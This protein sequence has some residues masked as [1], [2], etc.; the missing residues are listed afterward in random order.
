MA[1]KVMDIMPPYPEKQRTYHRESKKHK[2]KRKASGLFWSIIL[3]I[4]LASF[5]WLFIQTA[6]FET[7]NPANPG[8]SSP[9][10]SFELFSG[11]G[12]S[13]LTDKD[14]PIV[15]RI[16]T[17]TANKPYADKIKENLLKNGYQIER[18]VMDENSVTITSIDYRPN[19]ISTAQRAGNDLKTLTSTKLNENANLDSSID[20]SIVIGSE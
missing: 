10:G 1:K 19:Y 14:L 3:F 2:E 11:S 18:T 6:G 9:K 7:A 17:S 12:N 5:I 13:K 8:T 16:T 20:L 15:V 4:F